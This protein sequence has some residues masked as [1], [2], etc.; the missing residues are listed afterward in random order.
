MAQG[1]TAVFL[2]RDGVVNRSLVVEGKP[3]APR[4]L[5]D[6]RLLPGVR[7]AIAALRSAGRLVVVVTNQ[8]DLGHGLIEPAV[9]DAM[10]DRVR[11]AG[12]DAVLCCP[13]RQ[14][15]GCACRKPRPGMLLTAARDFGID[16]AASWM[17]GDRWNDIAAGRAAGC[18][19]VFIERGYAE[20]AA[21]TITANQQ[22]A[23]L[24]AAV[25][26]ILAAG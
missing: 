17:V 12:A 13:H 8:P 22:A 2:D 5:A 19:T 11:A 9:L 14:D 26:A 16:L 25:R 20:T 4:R 3:Y 6:F 24:P 7:A 18:R 15:E 21:R 1:R 10:H 23:N